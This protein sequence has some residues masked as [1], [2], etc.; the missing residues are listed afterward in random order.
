MPGN[1]GATAES[2]FIMRWSL[3]ATLF[4]IT[5][6]LRF[7]FGH[8]EPRQPPPAEPAAVEYPVRPAAP[9]PPPVKEIPAPAGGAS[10]LSLIEVGPAEIEPAA[11]SPTAEKSDR[12]TTPTAAEPVP[13]PGQDADW[14]TQRRL[15]RQ[16]FR[17]LLFTLRSALESCG[18]QQLIRN[19]RLQGE[20]SIE[21]TL[22][23]Q[24]GTERGMLKELVIE[25]QKIFIPLFDGCIRSAV[26]TAVFPRPATQVNMGTSYTLEPEDQGSA[27]DDDD[28]AEPDE[29]DA[30]EPAAPT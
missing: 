14:R 9:P 7:A 30:P 26:G 19:P 2:E 17:A 28:D 29:P 25:H 13:R 8:S 21:A 27:D 10:L 15:D 4:L 20:I 11:P 6:V 22:V 18:R 12:A 1:F 24:P 23:P 5:A 3:Y 16:A